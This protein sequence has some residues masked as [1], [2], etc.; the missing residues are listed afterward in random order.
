MPEGVE[1]PRRK[2][3]VQITDWLPPHFSAVS[4]YALAIADEEAAAGADVT[5]VG[6][7]PEP[8][9]AERRE[10]GAGSVHVIPVVRKRYDK[11]SWAK[12]LLWTFGTNALL[13]RRAWRLMRGSEV[14]RFTGSPPFLIFFLYP[15]NLIW[16][17]TLVYRITDFYPECIIAALGRPNALLEG[18]RRVTNI[19][20][21]RIDTFEAIGTDMADRLVQCGVPRERI[22]LRRDRSPVD[23]PPS[24]EALARP[25]GLAGKRT[26]LYSGNWGAAH[27]V[28]TF[29]QAYKRHHEHGD[30]S[31]VL[32]LNATGTGADEIDARMTRAG[33]PF[34]RQRLVPLERLAELLVAPDAHLITLRPAFTGYVLPSKVYGCIASRRPVLFVGSRGSDVH[35][36]CAADPALP[37][38]HVEVGD[39]SGVADALGRFPWPRDPENRSG[40]AFGRPTVRDDHTALG[41]ASSSSAERRANTI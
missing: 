29:F 25:P 31:F 20:R 24:T 5:V 19:L 6:L 9:A 8:M 2:R 30:G 38:R 12:R 35:R 22:L 11:S 18:L 1:I 10:V 14:I 7:A 40:L 36:L 39:V 37:Y 41:L 3:V 27:D 23:I 33:L 4:Q 21:R 13:L 34:V 16:R 26:I 28:E 15:A 17:R 32:W